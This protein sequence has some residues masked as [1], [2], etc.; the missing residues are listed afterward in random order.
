VQNLERPLGDDLPFED[1]HCAGRQKDLVLLGLAREKV[2]HWG[3]QGH[4]HL[5]RIVVEDESVTPPVRLSPCDL[6][7]L[8]R[9]QRWG[10]AQFVQQ[11]PGQIRYHSTVSGRVAT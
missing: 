7:T 2:A 8:R 1:S 10:D 3:W 9:F 6:D 11:H 4:V 5:G